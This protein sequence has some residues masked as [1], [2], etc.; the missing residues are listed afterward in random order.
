[1]VGAA[2]AAPRAAAPPLSLHAPD[3]LPVLATL[4]VCLINFA[5]GISGCIIFAFL[6]FLARHFSIQ[7]SS[8]GASVGALAAAY[9]L[10]QT[11]TIST[12]GRAADRFGRRPTLLLG[13]GGS[14][15]AM[16]WFGFA[17]TYVECLAA[18]FLCG[19][20]NGNVAV[21][22]VYVG[23]ITTASTQARGFAWL[24][25]TWGLATVLAPALGA[26]LSSPAERFPGTALDAPLLRH[27]PYLLPV[28]VACAYSAVVLVV[29]V[30]CLPETASWRARH[31]R[32]ALH[33]DGAAAA[34]S[35]RGAAAASGRGAAADAP[36]AKR[37]GGVEEGEEETDGLLVDGTSSSPQPPAYE[38][39]LL[40][41]AAA[42]GAAVTAAAAV[43]ATAQLAGATQLRAPLDGH[44]S[45]LQILQHPT[46]GVVIGCYCSLALVQV[47]FDELFSV[48]CSTPLA[49]NGLA[50]A[51]ADVG[52]IQVVQGVS[53]IVFQILIV[54]RLIRRFGCVKCFMWPSLACVP[55]LLAF[56]QV[57]RL[58][59][60]PDVLYAALVALLVLKTL[61]FTCAFTA[62]IIAINNAAPANALGAVTGTAQMCASGF[63]TAGP[64]LG[65]VLFTA[66]VSFDA[67]GAWRLEIP[68]AVMAFFAVV[69]W[70][71]GFSIPA[72]VET[73]PGPSPRSPQLAAASARNPPPLSNGGVGSVSEDDSF[74]TDGSGSSYEDDSD[75]E[76]ST[77]ANPGGPQALPV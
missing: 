32:G 22:K 48:F 65:G 27:F 14:A 4:L 8:V 34:G 51:A 63:R 9:F 1:M 12:W 64:A 21:A 7:E 43:A 73:P 55:V 33:A 62:I 23:E 42:P 58:A 40:D 20:L 5:E 36:A 53:Q 74:D 47:L 26:F 49:L 67:L 28:L 38:G 60:R 75:D 16:L 70:R 29:G 77:A 10:G 6:P 59:A 24:S 3:R 31:A 57:A 44:S 11:L 17:Q 39:S 52:G 76:D 41:D 72:S 54:P 18:R 45:M 50:W 61:F 25:L 66:A 19:C 37:E 71:T 35:G 46:A 2:A 15:C 68:Y 56:P 13:L 30:A 69:T